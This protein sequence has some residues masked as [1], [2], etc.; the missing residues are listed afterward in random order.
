[1]TFRADRALTKYVDPRTGAVTWNYPGTYN[2]ATHGFDYYPNQVKVSTST[3]DKQVYQDQLYQV[4]LNFKRTFGEGHDV[5]ACCF[6]NASSMP[7]AAH[8]LPTVR[9]GRHV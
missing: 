4:S 8:S 7:R 6:S 9:S 1:M 2:S 5:T 3:A